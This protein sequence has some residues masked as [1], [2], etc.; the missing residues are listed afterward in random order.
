MI[1]KIEEKFKDINVWKRGSE[2]APHK[3]L[4]LL[5]ILGRYYNDESRKVSYLEID[6]KLR[7]LLI[8]FGPFRKTYHPEFPFWYLQNDGLWEL[9]NTDRL[10]LRNGSSNPLRS[11]LLKYN[12]HGGFPEGIYRELRKNK[13]LIMRVAKSIL[14]AHF[15]NTIHQDILQEVGLNTEIETYRRR[16]RNPEFRELILKAYQ[17]KCAICGFDIKVGKEPV[18]LE[19]AHIKWHQAG[20]PDEECNGLALCTLHHK[21]FDRGAFTLS[22]SLKL[23]V[24]EYAHGGDS[25]EEWLLRFNGKEIKPP[26]KPTYYPE[27][28][29]IHW[30]I[31]EVFKGP[32]RYMVK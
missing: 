8:E 20:G 9:D 31:K 12:I 10:I 21:L 6:K 13:Q 1:S 3:P 14:E 4:L 19:G 18:A 5:Y 29:F 16:K 32:V 2:R 22:T 25:F 28:K 24:S 7:A 30:H 23:K 11:E 27:E 26:I 17:Y 15:P